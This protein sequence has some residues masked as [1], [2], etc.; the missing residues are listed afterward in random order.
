MK[1]NIHSTIKNISKQ[2]LEKF[3]NSILNKKKI[4]N[5]INKGKD[6]LLHINSK[7]NFNQISDK[8]NGILKDKISSK[9]LKPSIL[10]QSAQD[11]VNNIFESENNLVFLRQSR[12]WFN[13]ISWSL[14]TTV[15]FGV[16]WIS[17]ASLHNLLHGPSLSMN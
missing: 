5:R 3:K 13:A 7:Y 10:I 9:I 11:K 8:L 17:I 12:F 4:I 6:E 14:I 16:T 1:R 15:G 2:S